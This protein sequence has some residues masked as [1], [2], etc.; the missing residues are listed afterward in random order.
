L[1]CSIA[2]DEID[3]LVLRRDS[4]NKNNTETLSK[5]LSV[6]GGNEAIPN[7]LLLASTNLMEKID[8]AFLRRVV[9]IFYV[10][11]PNK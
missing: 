8:E 2:I 1:I 11:V 10:G 7:I 6:L 3:P 9:P 4:K 5:F